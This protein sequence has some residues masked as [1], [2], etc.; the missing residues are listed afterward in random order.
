MRDQV[1]VVSKE[2]RAGKLAQGRGCQR[3]P[4]AE[5]GSF[6]LVLTHQEVR[7]CPLCPS[8]FLSW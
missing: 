1:G 3:V 6:L 7:A 2:S 4:P 5:Q 8:T